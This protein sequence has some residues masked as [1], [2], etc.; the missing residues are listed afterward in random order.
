MPGLLSSLLSW[1]ALLSDR[2]IVAIR[3]LGRKQGHLI[4]TLGLVRLKHP[5]FQKSAPPSVHSQH[6][7]AL[8]SLNGI[9]IGSIVVVPFWITLKDPKYTPQ[10]GIT[11]GPMGNGLQPVSPV[12]R[13]EPG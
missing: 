10:T 13:L 2:R 9:P 3:R 8:H 11:M 4:K 1:E 5:L 12:H 7:P 6:V